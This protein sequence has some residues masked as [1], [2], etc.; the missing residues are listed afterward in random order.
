MMKSSFQPWSRATSVVLAAAGIIMGMQAAVAAGSTDWTLLGRNADMHHNS[1]L[2]QINDGTVNRLGVMWTAEMP[3]PDGLVGN[4][5]VVDGVVYQGGPM[6]RVYANDLRTGKLLWSFDPKIKTETLLVYWAQRINRG[7]A[8]S[9]DK[10]FIGSADCR[11][12]ALDRKTGK[13]LWNI[14]SCDASGK[15]GAYAITGA[16]RVGNGL[17]FIGNACGD[18][19]YGRGYVDA[20]DQKTG[21]RKWRFYTVPDDPAK[22][23]QKTP[24]LAMA[25]K[26]WGTNSYEKSNGCASV[27]EAIT[28]DEKLNM[29]YF[30]TDGPS[31][32][33]PKQRAAD[34][35]DELFTNSVVAVDA[36]TGKYR[37]HYK[38]TPNDGWNYTPTGHIMVA[39]L[40]VD[41]SVQRVV[42]TAPKNGFFYVLDAKTGKFISAKNFTP[43]N[44][45]SHIDPKTGRP[46][47]LP[48]ARYWE[49]ADG[50][51]IILPS[52]AGAHTWQPMAYNE[53]TGLVYIPV[54]SMPTQVEID[55]ESKVG[56]LIT[57]DYYGF[58]KDPKWQAFGELVAWDPVRQE[59]R[60]RAKRTLPMNGGTLTTAGNLVFQ[61]TADGKF[62]AYAADSGKLLW[63]FDVGGAIQ[64][65][66]STVEIDGR[67]IVLVPVGNG[68]GMNIGSTLARAASTLQT[69][70]QSRL[71]AFAVDAKT[72]FHRPPGLVIPKPPLPRPTDA[73]LVAKGA[74]LYEAQT[75]AYCHGHEVES[76]NGAIKDLRFASG[77]TH[78]VFAGIVIGGLRSAKGMPA[79]TH[80]TME[81]VNALQSYVLD[82][83]WKGYDADQRARATSK[84]R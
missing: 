46:V 77:E 79:F 45:A 52:T 66:P 7:L 15:T 70:T 18:S 47:T 53:A 24:E 44:W 33:N 68:G 8:V 54:S 9:G 75:C 41:K 43:V 63:S 37:W 17:V 13:Q 26:T 31:P 12:Y 10:I 73:T 4:P 61:G 29:V 25:A 1:P 40:P 49:K 38:V 67:Q 65:A 2:T 42:M 81:E 51:A 32:W 36:N 14:E 16:P 84:A 71:I 20:Y 39:D 11:L 83:A 62:E 27:W 50:K 58:G 21:K 69:R 72:E 35:G 3:T 5:L 23:K 30:G 56:G 82:Q 48:D 76:A 64:A 60:W 22:G 55:H 57:H 19:G 80:I 34:A 28:Y 6:A 78:E 74:K 59:A